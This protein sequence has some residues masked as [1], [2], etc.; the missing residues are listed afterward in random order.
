MKTERNNGTERI[1]RFLQW[2]SRTGSDD[3]AEAEVAG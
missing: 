1:E 2:K 3:V